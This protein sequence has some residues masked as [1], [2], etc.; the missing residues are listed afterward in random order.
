MDRTLFRLQ[1]RRPTN[2]PRGQ[3]PQD[4]FIFGELFI[5][6]KMA[7]ECFL[8]KIWIEIAMCGFFDLFKVNVPVRFSG[9]QGFPARRDGRYPF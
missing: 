4:N 1:A 9:T 8:Q 5:D 3:Q 6:Q 7:K 2:Q